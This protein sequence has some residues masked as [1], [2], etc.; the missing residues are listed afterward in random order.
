MNILLISTYQGV[1]G[2][3]AAIACSRLQKSLIQ[4]GY[5]CRLLVLNKQSTENA[6]QVTPFFNQ[7]TK[8]ELLKKNI[9]KGLRHTFYGTQ[10]ELLPNGHYQHSAPTSPYTISAHELYEWADIINLHWVSGFLDFKSFFS[11]KSNKPIVWTLHDM[12]PFTVAQVNQKYIQKNWK[13]KNRVDAPFLSIITPSKWLRK[14]SAA[15]SLF[16]HKAH[17]VI[18]YSIDENIFKSHNA[19]FCK[20]IFTINPA[21]KTILFVSHDISQVLKGIQFLIAAI[22]KIEADIEVLVNLFRAHI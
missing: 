17:F 14:Q 13:I 3:G 4:L 6:T 2:G 20:A 11:V 12:N 15:S 22:D 21:K 19:A 8:K 16:K 7:S 1:F 18:P 9:L 10:Y 5:D